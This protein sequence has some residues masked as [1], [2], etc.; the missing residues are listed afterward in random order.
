MMIRY[1]K[2][3]VTSDH[4]ATALAIGNNTSR[5][6]EL[7]SREAA[8]TNTDL[9]IAQLA[10]RARFIPRGSEVEAAAITAA[11]KGIGTNSQ[12]RNCNEALHRGREI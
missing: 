3:N 9:S 12:S 8:V 1:G 7:G 4:T 2:E 11:N 5:Q 10:Q 6:T